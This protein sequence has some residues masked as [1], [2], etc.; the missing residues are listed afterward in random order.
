MNRVSAAVQECTVLELLC[1]LEKIL[2]LALATS[3]KW[4]TNTNTP[5]LLCRFG[6]GMVTLK[7]VLDLS[8]LFLHKSECMR[9]VLGACISYLAL[10][11]VLPQTVGPGFGSW[12]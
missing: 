7:S 5:L 3:M 4:S 1:D 2:I 11:Q 8:S 10:S 9:M 12:C 6:A